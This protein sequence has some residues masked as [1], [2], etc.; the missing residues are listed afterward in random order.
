MSIAEIILKIPCWYVLAAIVFSLYYAIRG[1]V[2]KSFLI[3]ANC[4][5]MT[6]FQR[7][8]I[9]YIQEFIFK[10]IFTLSAFLSLYVIYYIVSSI[11]NIENIGVG[12][13]A[14]IIFLFIWGISGVSGYLTYLIVT[15]KYPGG[16]G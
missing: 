12:T 2:E 16:K 6:T 7:Y 3:N 4:P 10:I 9:E 11:K 8:I 15:G 5:G 14:L 13:A 1:V